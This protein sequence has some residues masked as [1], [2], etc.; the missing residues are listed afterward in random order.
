MRDIKGTINK[1]EKSEPAVRKNILGREF[2]G[3]S[4]V[5]EKAHF[6][7]VTCLTLYGGGTP[8]R[9]SEDN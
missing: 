7:V 3:F 6:G 4:A 9:A 2:Y 5:T 1:T 8:S